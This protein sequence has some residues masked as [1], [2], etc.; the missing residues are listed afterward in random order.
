MLPRFAATVAALFICLSAWSLATPMFGSA[1][2]QVHMVTAYAVVHRL[3]GRLTETGRKE[4]RL[5]AV[6]TGG[7]VC[8]AF[9]P[10][11]SASCQY[12][13]SEAPDH[14]A[15]TTAWDYP[16]FY[17][18]LVGW[19]TFLSSGLTG[20]YLMR[21]VASMWA[22]LLLAL[23]LQ[24][25][26]FLRTRGPLLLGAA[27]SITPAV[28]SFG[29]AVNPTGMSFAA[30]LATWT[31]GIALVRADRITRPA[32]A[33]WRV[34]APLCLFLLL[35]RDTV[36]WSSLIVLTLAV[37]APWERV[38]ELAHAPLAWIWSTAVVACAAL[39]LTLSGGSKATSFATSASGSFANTWNDLSWY[40]DQLGGGILGWL[41]TRLP[42]LVYDLFTYGPALMALL[43]VCLGERRVAAAIAAVTGMTIGAFLGIGM[44][45]YGYVQGRYALPLAF[46]IPLLGGLALA[47]RFGRR[48]VPSSLALVALAIIG[49]AHIAAFAQVMRRFTAGAHGAWWFRKRPPW[50]P[51]LLSPTLLM[52]A[53]TVALVSVLALVYRSMSVCEVDH[54]DARV[55]DRQG[56]ALRLPTS[57]AQRGGI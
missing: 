21:L 45:R 33:L 25:L 8:Y 38:R 20:L 56:K 17:Y 26:E 5:P 2:E 49:L 3:D 18:V 47:E 54:V 12:F 15:D 52:L 55:P 16:P 34:G 22:A 30:A 37:L 36:L 48:R 35:R 29:G 1:D 53:F 7:D 11:T 50:E 46:G 27:L 43:G 44:I 6:Y 23:A 31:G 39:Q 32:L 13:D 4:Y 9:Q 19:P 24:N 51:P 42:E 28:L 41:D 14:M 10:E 57:A 40:I